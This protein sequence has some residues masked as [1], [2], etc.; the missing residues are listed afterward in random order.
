VNVITSYLYWL[1]LI[2]PAVVLGNLLTIAIIAMW[3]RSAR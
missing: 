3:R 1:A 2:V